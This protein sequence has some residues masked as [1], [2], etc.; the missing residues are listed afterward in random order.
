[1]DKLLIPQEQFGKFLILLMKD[2]SLLCMN[3]RK[4]ELLF[5][6]KSNEINAP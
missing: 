3:L 5:T 1:M 6:L 2:N 4:T